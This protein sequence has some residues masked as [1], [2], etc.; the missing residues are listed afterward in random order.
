MGQSIPS[1]PPSSKPQLS[2]VELVSILFDFL[3]LFLLHLLPSLLFGILGLLFDD[4]AHFFTNAASFF[5]NEHRPFVPPTQRSAPS[6]IH[7]RQTSVATT[8][9]ELKE[10]LDHVS[11]VNT[12]AL[13]ECRNVS[14]HH[15]PE[16]CAVIQ[17][18]PACLVRNLQPASPSSHPARRFVRHPLPELGND[19]DEE[20]AED[21]ASEPDI[22]PSATA[23]LQHP[24]ALSSHLREGAFSPLS[25]Q[26]VIEPPTSR[27]V[28]PASHGLSRRF[29]SPPP[30]PPYRSAVAQTATEM[31]VLSPVSPDGPSLSPS[32]TGKRINPC[33]DYNAPVP[34]SSIGPKPTSVEQACTQ[35]KVDDGMKAQGTF[36]DGTNME[37]NTSEDQI[38]DAYQ[39]NDVLSEGANKQSFVAARVDAYENL[40]ITAEAKLDTPLML[41]IPDSSAV[42]SDHADQATSVS[43]AHHSEDELLPNSHSSQLDLNQLDTCDS[44]ENADEDITQGPP[45][46][47]HQED[48][49]EGE[50]EEERRYEDQE[51]GDGL[52]RCSSKAVDVLDGNFMDTDY[53]EIDLT[54]R[55]DP[56]P[57]KCQTNVEAPTGVDCLQELIPEVIPEV[58]AR[59]DQKT[60]LPATTDGDPTLFPT[61]D[62]PT[63]DI[64]MDEAAIIS[65]ASMEKIEKLPSLTLEQNESEFSFQTESYSS[66]DSPIQGSSTDPACQNRHRDSWRASDHD[67]FSE[68]PMMDLEG[69]GMKTSKRYSRQVSTRPFDPSILDEYD[70]LKMMKRS[71][72]KPDKRSL[73]DS[74]ENEIYV[75]TPVTNSMDRGSARSRLEDLDS[76]QSWRFSGKSA[77]SR[78]PMGENALFRQASLDPPSY[79]SP[80]L[81]DRDRQGLMD[82]SR[83]IMPRFTPS[84]LSSKVLVSSGRPSYAS[85]MGRSISSSEARFEDWPEYQPSR[86]GP[87]S[88]SRRHQSD[89]SFGGT[90]RKQALLPTELDEDEGPTVVGYTETASNVP[91]RFGGPRKGWKMAFGLGQSRETGDVKSVMKN[92]L[93]RR[94]KGSNLEESFTPSGAPSVNGSYH[95]GSLDKPSRRSISVEPDF[96]FE[97]ELPQDTVFHLLNRICPECGYRA[98][99]RKPNHKMKVEIPA[100]RDKRWVLISIT[101]TKTSHGR[102]TFVSIARSKDDISGGSERD[103]VA[104]GVLLQTRL[105]SHVEFIEDSFA[106]LKM[107]NALSQLRRT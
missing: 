99:V 70:S 13:P 66:P 25:A 85:R 38:I 94:R 24:R 65:V 20:S 104:A 96:T 81:S 92:I 55:V 47:Q 83:S 30:S 44:E 88:M 78:E 2:R 106:S 12:P 67:L 59:T 18:T 61:M 10:R 69:S 41:H 84:Q 64:V 19:P 105:G 91:Q 3:K 32:F 23:D 22:A 39:E 9:R 46:E 31:S 54:L 34:P 52:G 60:S 48:E 33:K 14:T 26:P 40:L 72:G 82:R 63:S 80:V 62:D 7:L 102:N 16:A 95:R 101:L 36:D 98:V 76:M 73:S 29:A 57:R 93:R 87:S 4:A 5:R 11:D 49:E 42:Q 103:I 8:V 89:M 86:D 74:Y 107:D 45:S 97:I 75:S 27:A 37:E 90:S 51:S 56:L 100:N 6:P 17:A 50:E 21:E 71:A 77:W 15:N 28:I 43:E 68:D 79:S 53:G 35:T 1:A 58:T